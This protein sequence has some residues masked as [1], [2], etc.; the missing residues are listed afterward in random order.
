M[1]FIPN[2][3][4]ERLSVL[5]EVDNWTAFQ[6]TGLH[7][8]KAN[9]PFLQFLWRARQICMKHGMAA[10]LDT[11]MAEYFFLHTVMH[12]VDH[13][14]AFKYQ[15]G[16]RC[17][18]TLWT[19]ETGEDKSWLSAFGNA[20]FR[21]CFIKPMLNPLWNNKFNSFGKDTVYRKI[22]EELKELNQELADVVTASVMY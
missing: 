6:H 7:L 22:Y 9:V 19:L 12:A 21:H 8:F 10:G 4:V 14:S 20:M 17:A 3:R 1:Q 18:A 2:L 16:L 11:E 13:H 5:D 15:S